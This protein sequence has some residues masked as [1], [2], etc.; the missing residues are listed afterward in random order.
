M[1]YLASIII[2]GFPLSLTN[3]FTSRNILSAVTMVQVICNLFNTI[4]IAAVHTFSF[5]LK[6]C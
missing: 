2:R 4:A 5:P 3:Y 1:F 6:G